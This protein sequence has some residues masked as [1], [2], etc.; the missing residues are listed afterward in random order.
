MQY[1]AG[2]RLYNGFSGSVSYPRLTA[3]GPPSWPVPHPLTSLLDNPSAPLQAVPRA[4]VVRI[5]LQGLQIKARRFSVHALF[6]KPLSGVIE[7]VDCTSLVTL[8]GQRLAGPLI[9]LWLTLKGISLLALL[10]RYLA[11]ALEIRLIQTWRGLGR[12]ARFKPWLGMISRFASWVS[13]RLRLFG[14]V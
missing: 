13:Y 5:E 8:L 12:L 14:F 2:R 9:H 3:G 10:T 1:V 4:L 11:L 6:E 7:I